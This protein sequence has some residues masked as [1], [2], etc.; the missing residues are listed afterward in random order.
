MDS[1]TNEIIWAVC[2]LCWTSNMFYNIFYSFVFHFALMMPSW[3]TL[4]HAVFTDA[5]NNLPRQY[6]GF[7]V[8]SDS[9]WMIL[10]SSYFR[11]YNISDLLKAVSHVVSL[12]HRKVFSLCLDADTP[13]TRNILF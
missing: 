1:E 5:N 12:D 4:A 7:E 6:L 2:E 10:D 8:H 9:S 3:I 11:G 13:S